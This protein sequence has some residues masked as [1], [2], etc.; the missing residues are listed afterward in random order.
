MSTRKIGERF[1]F[2]GVELEVVEEWSCQGCYFDNH[3][4]KCQMSR[5]QR[6]HVGSCGPHFRED[7]TSVIFKEVKKL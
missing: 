1:D 4:V 7:D 5:N 2:E 6:I 3:L